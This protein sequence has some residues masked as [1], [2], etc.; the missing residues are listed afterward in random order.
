MIIN[1]AYFSKEDQLATT[2]ALDTAMKYG[3]NYPKGPFEWK[4]KIGSKP[5]VL[6]LS[7]LHR[8]TRDNRYQIAP[9]LLKES[10]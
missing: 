1:E 5:I 7:E 9:S 6:L 8:V 4:D 2:E 3:A 10:L